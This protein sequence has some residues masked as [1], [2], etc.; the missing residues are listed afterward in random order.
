MVRVTQLCAK[1]VEE[2]GLAGSRLLFRAPAVSTTPEDTLREVMPDLPPP[3]AHWSQNYATLRPY[4]PEMQEAV[5]LAWLSLDQS[6]KNWEHPPAQGGSEQPPKWEP[7]ARVLARGMERVMDL[8]AL[9]GLMGTFVGNVLFVRHRYVYL[10]HVAC[11]VSRTQKALIMFRIFVCLGYVGFDLS[12]SQKVL[13]RSAQVG[14]AEMPI[15]VA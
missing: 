5:I 7:P 10:I 12:I 4:L 6:R 1:V 3:G 9:K 2:S 13:P 15:R 8:G 14:S 11:L